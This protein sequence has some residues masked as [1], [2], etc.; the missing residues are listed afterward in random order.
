MVFKTEG[1]LMNWFGIGKPRTKFGKRLD[2]IEITQLEL[3]NKSKLSRR[4]I[5]RLCNDETYT[6]KISTVVKIKKA[7]K[8]LGVKDPDDFF[9]M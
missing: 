7:L 3:E 9:D 1:D 6:P 4:T 5:S 8:S 2:R